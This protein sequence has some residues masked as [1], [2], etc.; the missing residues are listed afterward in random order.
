[1]DRFWNKVVK[2]ENDKCWE[3]IGALSSAGYGRFKINGKLESPHRISWELYNN[4]KVPIGYDIGKNWS[5]T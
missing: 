5:H 2:P 4:T 3:W 1:M